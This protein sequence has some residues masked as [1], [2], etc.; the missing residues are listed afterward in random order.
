V[1]A[2]RAAAPVACLALALGGCGLV[3]DTAYLLGDGRYQESAEESSPTTETTE[4]LEVVAAAGPDGALQLECVHRT[5][6]IER[7]WQVNKTYQRQGGFGRDTYTATAALDVIF[8]GLAA[9]TLLALCTHEDS[10]VSCWNMLWAAPYAVDLGYSLV[11][12]ATARPAVLVDKVRSGDRLRYGDPPLAE[13]PASCGSIASVWLG[14]VTGPSD[15]A[16]LN[17]EG[18]GRG[19]RELA[20]GAVPLEIDEAGALYL[21]DEAVRTWATQAWAGV[22]ALDGAG[23]PHPVQVDRCAALRPHAARLSEAE[24]ASFRRDCPLPQP[25]AQP[26]P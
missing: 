2:A 13:R 7:S 14:G 1:I 10:D 11:R 24:L 19:P 16:L 17:G 8:G 15:E 9:G 22:W 23:A 5:R 6:A 20:D 25:D 3:V 26:A 21:S 18:E 12:R 4:R